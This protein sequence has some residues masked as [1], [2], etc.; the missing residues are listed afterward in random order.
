MQECQRQE[1]Q[2][3]LNCEQQVNELSSGI[4]KQQDERLAAVER[5]LLF[6]WKNVLM[7]EG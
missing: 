6:Y 2:R 4:A 7:A 3:Y 5:K 1:N